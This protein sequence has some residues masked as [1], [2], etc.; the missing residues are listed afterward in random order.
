MSLRTDRNQGLAAYASELFAQRKSPDWLAQL[1]AA[2][3]PIG[4]ADLQRVAA[5]YLQPKNVDLAIYADW[6]IQ[7]DLSFIGRIQT[8]RAEVQ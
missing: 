1:Q 7:N 5:Q 6:R 4:P 8:Y 2:L 3:E